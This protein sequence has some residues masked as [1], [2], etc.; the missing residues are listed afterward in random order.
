[1][2]WYS[3]VTTWA[4]NDPCWLHKRRDLDFKRFLEIGHHHHS[5]WSVFKKPYFTN[6]PHCL[7]TKPEPLQSCCIL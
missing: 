4:D 2:A 5:L 3:W 6:N 7:A 1:M